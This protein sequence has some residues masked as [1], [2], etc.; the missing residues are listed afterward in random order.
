MIKRKLVLRSLLIVSIP[1]IV[2]GTT[3]S[4]A[5]ASKD[6]KLLNNFVYPVG[7]GETFFDQKI[8]SP[9]SVF[10][11]NNI[12][13][14]HGEIKTNDETY[15]SK[16]LLY[17][18][19]PLNKKN[20]S[21]ANIEN[22]IDSI[23]SENIESIK[24]LEVKFSEFHSDVDIMN[25]F[26]EIN[27]KLYEY[28]IE[29]VNSKL[30]I[31]WYSDAKKRISYIKVYKLKKEPEDEKLIDE[32]M[33]GLNRNFRKPN[34]IG[35]KI[36]FLQI[37]YS[38]AIMSPSFMSFNFWFPDLISSDEKSIFKSGDLSH[39][40]IQKK[41][42][43][44]EDVSDISYDPSNPYYVK[45][46][47]GTSDFF[48]NNLFINLLKKRILPFI[49]ATIDYEEKKVK[50]I[51]D[52]AHLNNDSEIITKALGDNVKNPTNITKRVFEVDMSDV[53][54]QLETQPSDRGEISL[55]MQNK[56]IVYKS[57]TS[58][59]SK[60]VTIP[61]IKQSLKIISSKMISLN[62]LSQNLHDT[63]IMINNI[64]NEITQ[65]Q[66]NIGSKEPV[67][68]LFK[69]P[70]DIVDNA[71]TISSTTL[72]DEIIKKINASQDLVFPK[73]ILRIAFEE[74][75][76]SNDSVKNKWS[77]FDTFTKAKVGD[78]S[79]R[80]LYSLLTTWNIISSVIKNRILEIAPD[81]SL[82]LYDNWWLDHIVQLLKENNLLREEEGIG[83]V[84]NNFEGIFIKLIDNA[85][86]GR[87]F[88][89]DKKSIS[90]VL[91][92]VL[93]KM[94]TVKREDIATLLAD[95]FKDEANLGKLIRLLSS[96]ATGEEFFSK[97]IDDPKS[98]IDL[99]VNNDDLDHSFM[100]EL[101]TLLFDKEL[102]TKI[103]DINLGP[104]LTG[105][106]YGFKNLSDYKEAINF[107]YDGLWDKDI[108]IGNVGKI[109][110]E[111]LYNV[112]NTALVKVVTNMNDEDIYKISNILKNGL[113]SANVTQIEEFLFVIK[114]IFTAFSDPSQEELM[115]AIGLKQ[116]TLHDINDVFSRLMPDT[117]S[118]NLGISENDISQ[119]TA[120]LLYLL[121]R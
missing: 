40:V 63:I 81:A 69:Q 25:K 18:Y 71:G 68:Y 113:H 85:K 109:L 120:N 73:R 46:N 31:Y 30:G 17:D 112:N 38:P 44:T 79:L 53:L 86:R 60:Y 21:V 28:K 29:H 82:D 117:D 72:L 94:N 37:F 118:D 83:S 3:L 41:Y 49:N 89:L 35:K 20:I 2:I 84:L 22:M 104:M 80:D 7:F 74:F 93:K 45:S 75:N 105:L 111:P 11:K 14:P 77:E 52:F 19:I 96:H 34:I 8:I 91:S 6:K 33:E 9:A 87:S 110:F 4:V 13:F 119:K 47:L 95:F 61:F 58:Q 50:Y 27:K 97:F 102:L 65:I 26:L 116:Q 54:A 56:D 98:I 108:F 51:I 90:I 23:D 114:K 103:L 55:D 121:T 92:L 66:E 16:N 32:F 115:D 43:G 15:I 1:G 70:Y 36:N 59:W 67:E 12:F 39:E 5:L 99:V 101:G 57:I 10:I 48:R 88:S 100:Q 62:G 78:D 106:K 42:G 76:G 107:I 64:H 24:N